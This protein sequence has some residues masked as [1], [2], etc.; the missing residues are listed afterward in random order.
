MVVLMLIP[1][2]G[3]NHGSGLDG[4]DAIVGWDPVTGKGS[5]T[6]PCCFV[7]AYVRHANACALGMGTPNYIKLKAAALAAP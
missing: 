6:S 1:W 5:W 7:F 3:N 4:F 2:A